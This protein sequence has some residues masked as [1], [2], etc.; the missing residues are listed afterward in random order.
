MS[1]VNRIQSIE[2]D[3]KL[4][5]KDVKNNTAYLENKNETPLN[6]IDYL[7]S[8]IDY[9]T[10]ILT[11]IYGD[12][13][14]KKNIYPEIIKQFIFKKY[15]KLLEENIYPFHYDIDENKEI[16][17]KLTIKNKNSPEQRTDEW[18]AYRYNRITASDIASVFCK[19]P[20]TSR[21]KLIKDKC[22][23]LKD[24]V[25]KTNNHMNHGNKYETIAT[26][27]YEYIMNTNIH[28]FG[29]LPHDTVGFLGASPDGISDEGIMLE[30]KCPLSRIIT[31]IPPI[32][33]WY[34]IQI[35][36]EV[37]NLPR[38]DYL[39]CKIVEVDDNEFNEH[40]QT[41]N[42]TNSITVGFII[43]ALNRSINKEVYVYFPYNTSLKDF[44]S[45]ENEKID[46]ILESDELDYIRTT[47]WILKDYGLCKI[48]R[49]KDWYENNIQHMSDFWD[50]VLDARK[51]KTYQSVESEPTKYKT[52]KSKQDIIAGKYI[53]Y[54]SDECN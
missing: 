26:Y 12:K 23:D 29:C 33:Y 42:I 27:F 2:K 15:D 25:F 28:E 44:E 38:C 49:D 21:N 37:A 40:I 50:E 14:V 22:K 13:V 5:L 4:I 54:D 34:Q 1:V 48:Y 41:N 31:G 18:Y 11:S 35:Q 20:F 7:F 16:L 10:I 52:Y 8:L 36:L 17:K 46:S 9:V 30:I 3:I 53:M 24:S 51:N 47:R 19:S 32:Y 6:H 43:E 39:E 45:W